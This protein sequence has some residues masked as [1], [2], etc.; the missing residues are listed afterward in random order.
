MK[1]LKVPSHHELA[2][3]YLKKRKLQSKIEAGV[4]QLKV[5]SQIVECREKLGLTQAELAVRVGV[6]QPFI[7]R[8]ENDEAAN[9]SLE[10]LVKIAQALDG[11]I[12]ICIRP[13]K[14]A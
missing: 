11:E 9:L 12:E 5:I 4:R 14:A 8:L 10:T 1:P 6:S 13:S 3:P 2:A 7:G